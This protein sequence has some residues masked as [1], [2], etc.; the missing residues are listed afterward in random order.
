MAND[1]RL[2]IYV[3]AT[4]YMALKGRVNDQDRTISQHVRY[5][6]KQDMIK[7]LDEEKENV[8]GGD[9]GREGEE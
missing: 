8:R 5:L 6:I 7:A 9:A 1:H 4:T 3:D 2:D